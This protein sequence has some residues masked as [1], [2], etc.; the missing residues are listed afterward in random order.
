MGWLV[1]VVVLQSPADV[2]ELIVT[3]QRPSLAP[4]HF[5]EHPG[6]HMFGQNW[7]YLRAISLFPQIIS[8][9]RCSFLLEFLSSLG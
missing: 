1:S 7:W 3:W 2:Q 8:A 4:D 5:Q 6:M 9:T